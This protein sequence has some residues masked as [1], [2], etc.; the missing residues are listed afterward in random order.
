MLASVMSMQAW[1][2]LSAYAFVFFA[3][4]ILFRDSRLTCLCVINQRLSAYAF[5]YF[6]AAPFLAFLALGVCVYSHFVMLSV[7]KHPV[8][9]HHQTNFTFVQ[10]DNS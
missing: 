2:R 9:F 1:P 3:H 4:T 8:T 10:D 7:T 5:V 6:G